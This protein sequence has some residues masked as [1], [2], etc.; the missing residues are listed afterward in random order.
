MLQLK[1][2]NRR[3]MLITNFISSETLMEGIQNWEEEDE[4]EV[5]EELMSNPEL[6]GQFSSDY[7]S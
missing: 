5:V 2:E 3:R 4:K 7:V 6:T 1:S